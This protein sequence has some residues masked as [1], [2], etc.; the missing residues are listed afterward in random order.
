MYFMF[1]KGYAQ[2]FNLRS[3]V[4]E[5]DGSRYHVYRQTEAGDWSLSAVRGCHSLLAMQ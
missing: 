3:F 2:I 5:V 1:P 4:V